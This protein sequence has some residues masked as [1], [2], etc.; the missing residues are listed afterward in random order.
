MLAA[1][2]SAS[3]VG[4]PVAVLTSASGGSLDPLEGLENCNEVTAMFNDV[5]PG[6]YNLSAEFTAQSGAICIATATV[7]VTAV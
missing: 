4:S 1:C 5:G 2:D 7:T 3:A 6:V